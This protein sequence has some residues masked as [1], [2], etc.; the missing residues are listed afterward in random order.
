MSVSIHP[1]WGAAIFALATLAGCGG[2]G[3]GYNR[4]PITGQVILD[5]K[6]L[7]NGMITF[8]QPSGDEP[9]ASAFI[10]NGVY[11]VERG[12]G[13]IPG[14]HRVSIWSR[15]P[16][17]R[18][19]RNPNDPGEMIEEVRNIIPPRYGSKS[20]L[21]AD[22]KEGSNTFDFKLEGGGNKVA[23]RGRSAQ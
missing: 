9:V 7:E 12:D 8:A 4:Q 6:P 11:K 19:I 22:V 21:T 2:S 13:P 3:D 20:E 14:A 15:K 5:G 1:A 10:E 16:T 18:Q 17:G 23:S